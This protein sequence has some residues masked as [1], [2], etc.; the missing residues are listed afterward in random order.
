LFVFFFGMIVWWVHC[1]SVVIVAHCDSAL[2]TSDAFYSVCHLFSFL[3]LVFS[4]LPPPPAPS[5]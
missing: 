1:L 4:F 5:S 3:F 2:C